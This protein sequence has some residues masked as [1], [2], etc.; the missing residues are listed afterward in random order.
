VT[1]HP[2]QKLKYVAPAI[3]PKLPYELVDRPYVG[4]EHTQSW[5]GRLDPTRKPDQRAQCLFSRMATFS[6]AS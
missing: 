2:K 1:A 5:T 3:N 6:S 4:L